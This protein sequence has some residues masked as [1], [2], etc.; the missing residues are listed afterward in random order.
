[1]PAEHGDDGSP[2]LICR[3]NGVDDAPEIAR[4]QYVGERLEKSG[5]ASILARG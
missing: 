2:I 5:E 4:Y 1:V 3:G